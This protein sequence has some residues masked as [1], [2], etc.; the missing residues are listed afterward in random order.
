[1]STTPFLEVAMVSMLSLWLPIVLS[2]VLVFVAS[3]VIHMVLGYHASDF[4]RVPA[5]DDVM[6]ALRGIPPGEYAMPKASSMKEMGD[7]AF[8]EKSRQGPVALLSVGPSGPPAIGANLAQ[9][10]AYSIV[11]GAFVAYLT[12]RTLGPG[13]DYLAVFRV[14]GTSAFLA[15]VVALWQSPIWYLRKWSTTLKNS[16]DG[17]IY[18][19]LTAGVFGWLWPS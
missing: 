12:G 19:L 2:A 4:D 5:E 10:F 8:V 13:A 11:V 3:S 14:A 16:F 9:W 15:Y 17:L 1:L 7:A 6:A 18:A